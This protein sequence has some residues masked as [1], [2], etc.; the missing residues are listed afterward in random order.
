MCMCVCVCP[1]AQLTRVCVCVA[2]PRRRSLRRKWRWWGSSWACWGTPLASTRCLSRPH[3]ACLIFVSSPSRVLSQ[4]CGRYDLLNKLYRCSG[5]WEKAIAVAEEHDRIN[6][7]STH[8]LVSACL[9]PGVCCQFTWAFEKRCAR[10]F[11]QYGKH[12][13]SIGD[14]GGA[15]REYEL[16]NTHRVEVSAV[17][18]CV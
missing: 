5:E 8:F 2:R 13:E 4:S 15:V 6:L 16:S 18:V 9:W 14:F 17:C 11:L 12:L 7:K 10:W 3:T 1:S